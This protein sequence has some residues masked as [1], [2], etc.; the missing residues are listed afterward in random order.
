MV[1][2][3]GKQPTLRRALARAVLSSE[4][5][6]MQDIS[7]ERLAQMEATAVTVA[8]LTSAW[9]P[10]LI[11]LC[12]QVRLDSVTSRVLGG[13]PRMALFCSAEATDRTG[14]EMEALTAATFGALAL[15]AQS[16][17]QGPRLRLSEVR[18]VLKEGGRSGR[19]VANPPEVTV[20]LFAQVRELAGRSTLT[21]GAFDV[22]DAL[23]KLGEVL[24]DQFK[25]LDSNC[26]H[27]VGKDPATEMTPLLEGDEI[28]VLPPVSG[29]VA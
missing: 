26:S 22:Q 16:M 9:T 4:A 8:A 28:S 5:G 24:G 27:W 19:W 2:V 25:A 14:V 18:L 1:N 29:G 3:T 21:L 23:S 13:G 11:P 6:T 10:K 20:R 7:E 15:V 12:H 17:E